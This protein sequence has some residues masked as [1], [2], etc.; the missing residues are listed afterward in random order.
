[1]AA[2]LLD[3]F[4]F[5]SVVLRG[6]ALALNSLVWGG[7][8]FTV[9]VLGAFPCSPRTE[10]VW[11]ACRKLIAWSAVALVCAQSCFVAA[12][13]VILSGTAGLGFRE[14]AGANYVLASLAAI[15][16]AALIAG[17]TFATQRPRAVLVV[18]AAVALTS[19]VTMSHAAARL[20]HR[21]LLYLLT[22]VH[23]AAT[24]SWVG[25]IPYL[26]LA[27]ARGRSTRISHALCRRFSVLALVSVPLLIAS[28]VG[29]SLA[30]VGTPSA[31]YGTAYG[32]MVVCKVVL[33]GLLLFLG[34][35]NFLIVRQHPVISAW[36]LPT[37]RR[38]AEAEMG[39]GFTIILAAASL[40]SQPPAVD[41]QQ[42]RLTAAEIAQRMRPQWPV[43]QT[44][45]L[46]DLSPVT[47]LGF[48]RAA[49]PVAFVPGAVWH[50][51]T[52]GD[53]EWSEY[54]HHW[55]GLIVLAAGLLAV[56]ARAGAGWARHWPLAFLGLSV[57]LFIRSDPENWPLGPRSFWQSF[58]VAEV[59][60]HR[61]FVLLIALFA[62]FEWGVRTGRIT[63]RYAAL[64]FPAVC[65]AGGALLL[66][67]AHSLGNIK[68]E[69]LA[70]LSHIPLAILGV[71]A[72]W[73]RWLEL[74]LS[75]PQQ[76][77][78]AWVWPVCF[79]LIG[80]VLLNYRES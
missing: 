78:L 15:G 35:L 29:M 43:L 55:A 45:P 44:P 64:V 31:L 39:I 47:P 60:Q 75:G 48:D 12:D 77:I 17:L 58:A 49:G 65:A 57:F 25:G 74:R 79:V 13:S 6:T 37:L 59:V 53:I 69:L 46:S 70:E 54:N 7:V 36:F 50:P 16:A 23:Q 38:L 4:G 76:R 27:L 61:V 18:P 1:V 9:F 52:R 30:Y 56:L 73:S 33:L 28:G 5:L 19:L 62:A 67:H 66:T 80:G 32:A 26:L 34:G 10:P 22:T 71:A 63:S 51:N 14:I 20:E 68:E 41:L 11:E 2:Q 3:V 21:P 40:T 72:G 8:L 42:G 24:A